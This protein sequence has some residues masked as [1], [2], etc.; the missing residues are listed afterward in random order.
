MD[1]LKRMKRLAPLP[2]EAIPL[3][4]RLFERRHA[5]CRYTTAPLLQERLLYLQ[6]LDELKAGDSTLRV[7]AQYQLIIMEYLRFNAIR[8]VSRNEIQDTSLR[9]AGNE[10]VRRRKATFSNFAKGR[11]TSHA[12]SW[13]KMLGCLQK[14]S[15]PVI[16]FQ[17]YRDKYL[18]YMRVEQGLAEDTVNSRSPVLKDFLMNISSE[19]LSFE[20]ISAL[21]IDKALTRKHVSDGYSRRSVQGYASVIR[22]FLRYAENQQWCCRGLADAVKAPRVYAQETLPSAPKRDDVKKLLT[23]CKTDHLTDIR[24]YAILMLLTVYGMRRS[25]VA[26]L[27]LED[28]DWKK[29]QLYMRRAKGSKPQTFPLSTIVGE[30]IIRYLTEVRPK[31]CR[32]REVFIVRRSPYQALTAGAVYA[33]VNRRLKPLN[34]PIRHHGPHA[35]RHACATHLINEGF[36]LKEI[37][38]HLGHRGVETTRIYT[39]VDLT[40]L[41]KVADQEWGGLL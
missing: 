32:L 23:S 38:D 13:F 21:I 31:H 19:V 30:A 7:A 39:K 11:F 33:L 6:C 35:L 18:G 5:L 10:K 14:E 40:N 27:K 29:E 4:N 20:A 15:E 36:S 37:S 25:E 3:F 9:W 17:E 28:I 1:W 41:R 2:E 12:V 16:P 26:G 24:D 34:L 8:I 22:S